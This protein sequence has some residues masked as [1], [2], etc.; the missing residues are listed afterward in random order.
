MDRRSGLRVQLATYNAGQMFDGSGVPELQ[1]WL[2]PTVSESRRSGYA[3]TD[4]AAAT[5]AM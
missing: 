3:T 1:E 4:G 5:T 2:I